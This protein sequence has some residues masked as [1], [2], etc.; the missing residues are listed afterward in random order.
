M[1]ES[2]LSDISGQLAKARAHAADLQI[3]LERTEA[4]RQAYQQEK[5][6]TAADE[7]ISEAMSS[8]IITGLRTRYLDLVNRETDW[9]SRYGK[10]H[11]AVVT[12][13]NQIRDIRKSIR[14]ELGR[15]VETLKSEYEIAKKRQ[16]ELDKELAA[17]VSQSTQT[18]RAQVA[19][20]SLE[21]AAQSYRKLY[22]NFLAQHTEAV[23]QQTF[24]IS[25]ARQISP[26]GASQTSPQ[27]VRVWIMTILAG[28]M[29]GVGL[30]ALREMMDRG[31]RTRDQ[32]RSVL[33]TE[34]L[35]LVPRVPGG[36]RALLKQQAH[37]LR[38][39]STRQFASPRAEEGASR[40]IYSAP[41]IIRTITDSPSSQYADAIRS[42]KV[43]VDL[44]SK[45]I[46]SKTIGVTSC[47]PTE[48]KSTV[49]AAMAMLIAQSGARVILLDCDF[50]RPSLSHSLSRGAKAGLLDVVAGRLDLADAVFTDPDTGMAFLPAGER[51]PAATE[52]LAS[53]AAKIFFETL[54]RKYDYVIVDLA[55]LAAGIHA[56][57]VAGLV[58]CY[59]LV[60]EWG[61]TKIDDVQYALRNSP[62][63]QANIA[64]AV[65]NKVNMNAMGRYDSYGANYCY[66]PPRHTSAIN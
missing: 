21:A 19:L 30:G 54:K 15:I 57:A 59:V 12:L 60:I 42:I 40:N 9:S 61:T 55:P 56:G 24:P 11:T 64:G 33:A 41:T 35:A 58:D 32:V 13:R 2:E 20:F 65:L 28:G 17:L 16:D 50:H 43:T 8:S 39:G 45:A 46:G 18:N 53:P 62:R 3:R 1:N 10:N 51:A 34:C 48:G 44:N 5:H 47:L 23:Q 26:A 25:D 63:V 22:D 49:A 37:A 29:L 38:P 14:D 6:A 31:F 27:P 66:A 7:N 36:P 4:V 52:I